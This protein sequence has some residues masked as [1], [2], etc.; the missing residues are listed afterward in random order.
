[1]SDNTMKYVQDVECA[2]S[3]QTL[4]VH[5]L[6]ELGINVD[7]Q[8]AKLKKSRSREDS[9]VCRVLIFNR[10]IVEQNRSTNSSFDVFH[11]CRHFCAFG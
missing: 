7:L 8:P 1:M 3:L 9:L 4:V 6:R 11:F 2:T 10:I 5:D